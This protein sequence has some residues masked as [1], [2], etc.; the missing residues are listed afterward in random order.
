MIH[1]A[2]NVERRSIKLTNRANNHQRAELIRRLEKQGRKKDTELEL[3]ESAL[4]LAGLDRPKIDLSLFRSHLSKIACDVADSIP[5]GRKQ[6][7]IQQARILSEILCDR[8][9]YSGDT[10]TYDDPQNANLI[11]VIERRKGLPVALA[12]LYIHAAQKQGWTAT[13]INFPGHFLIRLE[14]NGRQ[15]IVDPFNGGIQLSVA[16]LIDLLKQL[17][18]ADAVLR[19]EYYEPLT[20]RQVLIRLLNNIKI[21]AD[22][23]GDQDRVLQILHRMTLVAPDNLGL[24]RESGICYAKSGNMRR[25]IELFENFLL[26]C[27]S[28]EARRDVQVLLQHVRTKLN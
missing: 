11:S 14:Y 4:L 6:D 28:N 12:I 22:T 16:D 1:N 20:N 26:Q 10:A 19:S 25:A 8:H 23:M 21:R 5:S 13:G 24:M 7:A 15:V 2:R 17:A 27:N 18:G 3:A 9:K